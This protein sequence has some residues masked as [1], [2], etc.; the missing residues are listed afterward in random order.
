MSLPIVAIEQH[1]NVCACSEA[2][3]VKK[4]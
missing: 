4:L 3:I 2:N 1:A